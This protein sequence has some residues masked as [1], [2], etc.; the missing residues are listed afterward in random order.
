M[1]LMPESRLNCGCLDTLRSKMAKEVIG[2]QS[3]FQEKCLTSDAR[4]IIMGG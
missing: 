3:E 2:P 4:I 1:L